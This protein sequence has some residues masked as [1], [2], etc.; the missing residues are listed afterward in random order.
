MTNTTSGHR[1]PTTAT[2]GALAPSAVPVLTIDSRDL[3]GMWLPAETRESA[4]LSYM[5]K[6]SRAAVGKPRYEPLHQARMAIYFQWR[7]TVNFIHRQGGLLH[8]G[9][10]VSA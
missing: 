1:A 4:S 5:E 10:G 2:E 8:V 3:G 7:E 6:L 9:C